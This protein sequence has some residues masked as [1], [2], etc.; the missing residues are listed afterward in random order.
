MNQ[1]AKQKLEQI[2]REGFK[3]NF[4]AV[5]SEGF[6][7]W[8]KVTLPI[9]GG[10]FIVG[11]PAGLFFGAMYPLI[12][13]FSYAELISIMQENPMLMSKMTTGLV[14]QLK[15]SGL[16]LVLVLLF[17]PMYG[18]FIKL[19]HEADTTG[20]TNFGTLFSYYKAPYFINL[21]VA[22]LLVAL[23]STL[24]G[25]F[26]QQIPIVGGLIYYPFIIIISIF[27]VYV[28]SLIIFADASPIDALQT[29][30]KL[31]SKNVGM[32]AAIIVVSS[33][34]VFLGLVACCIGIVFTMS[35]MYVMYYLVY[36]QT[37]G[38][39]TNTEETGTAEISTSY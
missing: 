22:G 34:V 17:S 8:K 30:F 12:M 36:K 6:Q 27:T 14:P 13:G 37:I 25:V 39:E 32:L 18:G 16:S 38:F 28:N 4:E 11:I 24:P 1:F 10:L 33:L 15:T 9:L 31:A 26:I 29:S 5:F 35:F 19:C 2:D 23:I 3:L 7:I 21:A 20:N